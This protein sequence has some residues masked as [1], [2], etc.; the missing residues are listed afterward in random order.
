MGIACMLTIVGV[1]TDTEGTLIS[2]TVTGMC[3]IAYYEIVQPGMPDFLRLSSSSVSII[4]FASLLQPGMP[5]FFRL[6]TWHLT[7][8]LATSLWASLA[9]TTTLLCVVWYNVQVNSQLYCGILCAGDFLC[10]RSG[11]PSYVSIFLVSHDAHSFSPLYRILCITT[12]ICTT[13][14]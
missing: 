9:T 8:T 3:E 11:S 7:C 10:T 1:I 13:D 2:Y 14:L 5:D 4:S 12:F 6:C